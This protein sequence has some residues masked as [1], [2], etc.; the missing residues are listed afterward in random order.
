MNW[1]YG[2]SLILRAAFL[3]TAVLSVWYWAFRQASLEAL[4]AVSYLPLA[5]TVAPE[6]EAPIRV[7]EKT[8][9]WIFQVSIEREVRNPSSG[10]MQHIRSVEFQ[11][12]PDNFAFF[13]VGWFA[14]LGLALS[15]RSLFRGGGR[16]I[17]RGVAWQTGLNVLG[18]VLYVYTNGQ[19]SVGQDG[20]TWI[21]LLK[22]LYHLDYL[23]LPFVGPIAVAFLLHEE[24]REY[25]N[26][27]F[28]NL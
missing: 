14:Y 15:D 2:R 13:A 7:N 1:W 5:F 28:G 27:H 23:V 12:M 24:W 26:G 8:G 10:A 9:E 19:G 16:L 21:W 11:A 4:K 18:V 6:T 17:P 22:Y 3:T 20:D 25:W